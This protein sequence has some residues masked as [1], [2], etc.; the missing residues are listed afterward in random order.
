[1][2]EQEGRSHGHVD[3]APTLRA[4]IGLAAQCRD[5]FGLE[6]QRGTSGGRSPVYGLES[7]QVDPGHRGV[8][9]VPG[10]GARG[11]HAGFLCA[12]GRDIAED[13]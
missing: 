13:A 3:Q 8:E 6:R 4:E 9:P 10:V 2:I 11:L 12:A 5:E 7:T 1:L